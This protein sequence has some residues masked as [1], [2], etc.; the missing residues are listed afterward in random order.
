M[1]SCLVYGD[2]LAISE[3]SRNEEAV[4]NKCV[5][6]SITLRPTM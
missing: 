5:M 3:T 4:V 1:V 2:E 6:H